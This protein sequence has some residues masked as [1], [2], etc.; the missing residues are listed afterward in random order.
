MAG[1][2]GGSDAAAGESEYN[3]TPNMYR[4][5]VFVTSVCFSLRMS[6]HIKHPYDTRNECSC[7]V[8]VVIFLCDFWFVMSFCIV[9][10]GL[11]RRGSPL[12]EMD[13]GIYRMVRKT[14]LVP[15]LRVSSFV[16][17]PLFYQVFRF[18][19]HSAAGFETRPF[20]A[21]V[22]VCVYC[23]CIFVPVF[24][25]VAYSAAGYQND[26]LSFCTCVCAGVNVAIP[27]KSFLDTQMCTL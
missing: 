3:S 11:S 23:A 22:C 17:P 26:A 2:R 25:F 20:V 27:S 10:S 4:C 19:A 21:C 24:R 8:F 12:L 13:Y 7:S 5:L 18:A 6:C 9:I 14:H 16:F 15:L 1:R